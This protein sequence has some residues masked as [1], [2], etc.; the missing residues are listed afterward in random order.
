L[1]DS[2]A[3]APDAG[4]RRRMVATTR[5][6]CSAIGRA[7]RP[8]RHITMVKNDASPSLRPE[9]A[10]QNVAGRSRRQCGAP[11]GVDEMSAKLTAEDRLKPPE[12]VSAQSIPMVTRSDLLT[13]C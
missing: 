2:A 6:L 9:T 8:G 7:A 12:L 11:R 13:I 4:S 5:L 10:T 1:F 3:M